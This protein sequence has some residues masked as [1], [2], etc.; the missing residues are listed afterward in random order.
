[1]FEVGADA[2]ECRAKGVL[3][4]FQGHFQHAGAGGDGRTNRHHLF[5][6][7][8]G[9]LLLALGEGSG[10][11]VAP[12]FQGRAQAFVAGTQ[13]LFHLLV[14]G[15]NRVA[16][17]LM[18]ETERRGDPLL[19]RADDGF[20][21]LR[22]ARYALREPAC[23]VPEHIAH[24]DGDL[25]DRLFDAVL[26][27]SRKSVECTRLFVE[28]AGEP[29]FAQR[30]CGAEFHRLVVEHLADPVAV[31]RDGRG[32]SFNAAIEA[33]SKPLFAFL[34]VTRDQGGPLIEN[35]GEAFRSLG[36]V[37]Q[38][39]S[40]AVF[41][42]CKC[43]ADLH[44]FIVKEIPEPITILGQCLREGGYPLV[45][46]FAEALASFLDMPSDLRSSIVQDGRK[47]L[48]RVGDAV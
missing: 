17:L 33:F 2:I 29:V 12:L 1:M 9:N 46:A 44:R 28:Y 36:Q 45:K 39:A 25:A 42:K 22:P 8:F 27:V 4:A 19:T 34:H 14:G 24:P 38:N 3:L 13:C 7:Q 15:S 40:D 6:H 5:R 35:A 41:A 23:A 20:D 21:T 30:K 11:H 10:D 47:P 48:G 37:G 16:E 32:E 18:S 43:R 31:R 26:S